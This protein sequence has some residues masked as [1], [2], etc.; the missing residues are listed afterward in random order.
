MTAGFSLRKIK[1]EST[2]GQRLK[3]AR[4]RRKV[5]LVDAEIATKIRGKFIAALEE[6]NWRELPADAYT[7]G[8]VV[9]YAKFLGLDVQKILEKY[10]KEKDMRFSGEGENIL[11]ASNIKEM[12]VIITPRLILPIVIGVFLI[13]V[14][15]YLVYQV[16]GFAGA[17]ELQVM[18]PSENAIFEKDVIEV[19]GITDSSAKVF[20]NK[21]QVQVSA[22]GKFFADYKLAKGIN[23]IEVK[24]Q[25]KTNKEKTLTYTVEYKPKT[26]ESNLSTITN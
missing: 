15:S 21:D 1:T 13:S 17:P 8:F 22:D 25:G 5:S 2:L 16:Y 6:D 11:P 24:S 23:V 10:Q 19:S 18:T 4:L 14:F 3:K 26:A 7:K 12:K 20:V 9:R